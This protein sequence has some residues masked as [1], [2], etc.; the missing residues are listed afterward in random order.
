M[1]Y[2]LF[3]SRKRPADLGREFEADPVESSAGSLHI[4]D[5]SSLQQKTYDLLRRAILNGKL[6]PGHRLVEYK[7]A[8]QLGVSRLPVREAIRKLEQEG[9]VVV[10]PRRAVH[11]CGIDPVEAKE[12]YALRMILEGAAAGFAAAHASESD[13]QRLR[14]NLDTM[15]RAIAAQDRLGIQEANYDFHDTLVEMCG[16]KKLIELVHRV[17]DSIERFRRLYANRIGFTEVRSR[18]HYP[19][20]QAIADRDSER[21]EQLMRSHLGGSLE[22]LLNSLRSIQDNQS[23]LDPGG[24]GAISESISSFTIR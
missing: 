18:E 4:E 13:L 20:Y 14:D 16:N 23:P 24:S 9:L 17:R 21:S 7:L 12:T 5:R 22:M 6:P 3:P 19:I 8:A 11:V 15:E 10:D 2:G 1:E